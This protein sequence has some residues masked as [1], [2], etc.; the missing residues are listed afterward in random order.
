MYYIK[1]STIQESQ[2]LLLKSIS[3]SPHFLPDKLWR[4]TLTNFP[5]QKKVTIV[6]IILE[7]VSENDDDDGRPLNP[8]TN[9]EKNLRF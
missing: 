5:M 3:K 4:P 6:I 7:I 1:A 8:H 9:M 2:S